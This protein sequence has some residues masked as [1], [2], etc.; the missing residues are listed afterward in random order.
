MLIVSSNPVSNVFDTEPLSGHHSVWSVSHTDECRGELVISEGDFRYSSS[1]FNTAI[2]HKITTDLMFYKK[3]RML[4]AQRHIFISQPSWEA[5][6]TSYPDKWPHS[7]RM[8]CNYTKDLN[9][10]DCD[11]NK[12]T[13]FI[14]VH[15]RLASVGAQLWSYTFHI[16]LWSSLSSKWM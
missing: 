16:K 3:L 10:S 15:M 14:S 13:A 11:G 5:L 12:R 7:V 4:V 8:H 9:H 2:K 6:R 1:H